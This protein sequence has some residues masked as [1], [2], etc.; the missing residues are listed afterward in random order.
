[1]SG[2]RVYR[3][4]SIGESKPEEAGKLERGGLEILVLLLVLNPRRES[5]ES[6]AG[7]P[8]LVEERSLVLGYER[9]GF[10][11]AS[12][13]LSVAPL[14]RRGPGAYGGGELPVLSKSRIG[15]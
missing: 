1:M 9:P 4:R 14:A 3:G 13:R 6:M 12:Q 5:K 2:E 11:E 10:S 15:R 8:L 7:R